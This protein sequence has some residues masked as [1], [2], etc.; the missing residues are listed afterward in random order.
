[1]RISAA[2]ARPRRT[3]VRGSFTR[4]SRSETP[5]DDLDRWLRWRT[6]S[7]IRVSD[8]SSALVNRQCGKRAVARCPATPRGLARRLIAA[9]EVEPWRGRQS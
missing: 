2:N 1:M 6:Y 8:S 5:A 9:P 4:L 3:V 7:R